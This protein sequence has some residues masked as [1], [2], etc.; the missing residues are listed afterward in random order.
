MTVSP[1]DTHADRLWRGLRRLDR[2]LPE[3]LYSAWLSE[4]EE[5][6]SDLLST[7]RLGFARKQNPLPLR[8]EA[9]VQ[10]VQKAAYYTGG[11]NHRFLGILRFVRVGELFLAD[12]KPNADILPLM[13]EHF[14][15]RFNTNKLMI[16]DLIRRRAIVSEPSGWTILDLPPGDLPP[17]PKDGTFE[18]L[19]RDYFTVTANP[20]RVNT[21]LQRQFVPLRV[22]GQMTEFR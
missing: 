9:F 17:L 12:I 20:A 15:M 3:V 7:M 11:E 6:E 16:R 21:N 13:G 5:I 4:W 2:E 22:R 10:R 1:D 8:T 19:W 18:Q 14:Y